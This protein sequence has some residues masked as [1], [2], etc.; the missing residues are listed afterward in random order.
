[1]TLIQGAG[2]IVARRAW[3]RILARPV[4]AAEPLKNSRS[5]V[6][7]AAGSQGIAL[8]DGRAVKIRPTAV[9]SG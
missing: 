7:A 2:V 1:M 3:S 8:R 6:S 5:G 9:D 4:E